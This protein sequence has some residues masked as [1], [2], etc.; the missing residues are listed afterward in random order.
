MY[1]EAYSVAI[2]GIDGCIVRAE[3]DVSDGLPGFS[4]VGYL[5]GEVREAKERVWIALRNSG[6]KFLP[7]KITVNLSPADIRKGGTSY[8][9]SIS[10]AVL[11]AFG[12]INPEDVLDCIFIG[13]L[14]LDGRVKGVSGVLPMVYAAMKEGFK[15]VILSEDNQ[16]E[17]EIVKGINVISITRLDEIL[18]V[19]AN[20][21]EF[22]INRDSLN[23]LINPSFKNKE[24]FSDVSGQLI[25]KRAVEVAVSGMHNILMVGPP[26]SGKTMLAKRIPGIMPLPDFDEIMEISKIYS[27]SGLLSDSNPIINTRPF[28]APH[29][30]I[31]QTALVGGGR[32]PKPG[33]ISLA[34]GGVL[35]LD[36]L[37]EFTRQSIE[38]LRQPLEDGFVNV[39]RLGGS[40]KYPSRITLVGAMNPCPCGYYPDRKKCSCPQH[41]VN[42]YLSKVSRPMLDRIDICTE[43]TL[44][45]YDEI[46]REVAESSEDIRKRV[47]KAHTIQKERYAK[48]DFSFNAHLNAKGIKKYCKLTKDAKVLIKTIFESGTMFVRAHH[49][50]LKVARTLADMDEKDVIDATHVSEA[51]SYRSVD[52]KF[53]NQDFVN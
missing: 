30:T 32:F 24:D 15:Y 19:V 53:W 41:T 2:M 18:D 3:A 33:E 21:A 22:V 40:F 20:K 44:L 31:T 37:P 45:N 4:L 8:D 36:E 1:S 49:K 46:N 35:F 38:V 27:V 5:A 28:R 16:S 12:Y 9:L 48:E 23:S 14:S 29:H 6:F 7:K 26:G 39:S 52:K 42:R 13:E 25:A 34:N 17:A 11:S 47:E 51:V 43:T 10:V 50:I